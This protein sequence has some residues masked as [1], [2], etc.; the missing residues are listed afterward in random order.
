VVVDSDW[1]VTLNS[2]NLGQP[3]QFDQLKAGDTLLIVNV[4]LRNTSSAVANA[5]SLVQWSLHD[6]TGQTY[7]QDI[8]SGKSGPDGTI[9][10]GGVIRGDIAY[11]VPANVH[12]FTLQFVAG[13]GSSD[14]AEW[15][16]TV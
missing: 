10:P 1:T 13:I 2:A 3:G 14:L 12:S 9:V 7:N 15:N 8:V 4:S 11:E 16:V 6:S 5:S